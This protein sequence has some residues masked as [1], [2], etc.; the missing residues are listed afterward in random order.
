MHQNKGSRG[1]N[2]TEEHIPTSIVTAWLHN[3]VDVGMSPCIL[4]PSPLPLFG[5]FYYCHPYFILQFLI[6][7]LN[8]NLL[9]LL[10][11]RK[12]YYNVINF[13]LRWTLELGGA[14]A[15]GGSGPELETPQGGAGDSP[16]VGGGGKETLSFVF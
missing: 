10:K 7:F 15:K 2:K 11:C 4:L 6:V 5:V 9:T 8:V 14:G 13:V 12:H 1:G 16:E 3:K